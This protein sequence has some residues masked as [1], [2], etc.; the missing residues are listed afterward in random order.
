[1]VVGYLLALI[2][3]YRI[4]YDICDIKNIY[5]FLILCSLLKLENNSDVKILIF[6]HL[7][8]SIQFLY[9]FSP[10]GGSDSWLMS[11]F[12]SNETHPWIRVFCFDLLCFF[13]WDFWSLMLNTVSYWKVFKISVNLL[14]FLGMSNLSF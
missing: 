1:M 3:F 12:P 4:F 5:L 2:T 6:V 14:A 8:L 11:L 10:K 7:N 9:N 13:F